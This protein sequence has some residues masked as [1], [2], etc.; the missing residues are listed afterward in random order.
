MEYFAATTYGQCSAEQKQFINRALGFS[1]PA[2]AQV[3]YN[4]AH[5]SVGLISNSVLKRIERTWAVMKRCGYTPEDPDACMMCSGEACF[6]CGAGCWD[7]SVTDCEHD[8]VD[9]HRYPK[10]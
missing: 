5:V 2:D 7:S 6:L 1:L 3:S 8:I 9:R 4:G 10:D